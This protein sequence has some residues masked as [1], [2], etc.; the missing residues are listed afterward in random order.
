VPGPPKASTFSMIE[1]SLSFGLQ[2]W[3]PIRGQIW[4]PI[5]TQPLGDRIGLLEASHGVVVSKSERGHAAFAFVL[6]ELERLQWQSRNV[7]D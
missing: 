1:P 5:D 4:E 6:A 7:P 2:Y 3:T